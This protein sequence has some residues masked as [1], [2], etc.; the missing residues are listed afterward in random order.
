M[1]ITITEDVRIGKYILEKGDRIRILE[2]SFIVD[3]EGGKSVNA[4]NFSVAKKLTDD[5]FAHYRKNAWVMEVGNDE[6]LY[7]TNKMIDTEKD[8]HRDE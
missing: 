7:S 3:K 4:S 1:D 5:Y 2:K 8:I 6:I